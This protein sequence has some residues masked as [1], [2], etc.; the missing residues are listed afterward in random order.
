[1]DHITKTDL[2][3][4]D[5]YDAMTIRRLK[6][7]RIIATEEKKD[8]YEQKEMLKKLDRPMRDETKTY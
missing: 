4:V 8:F 6:Q 5:C 2:K 3:C 7:M 1:M